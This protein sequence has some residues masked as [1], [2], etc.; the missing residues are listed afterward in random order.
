MKKIIAIVIAASLAAFLVGCGSVLDVIDELADKETQA[1]ESPTTAPVESAAPTPQA[2]PETTLPEPDIPEETQTPERNYDF[3]NTC[4]GMTL[5]EVE[6]AE[7]G[8]VIDRADDWLFFFSEDVAG[9]SA[10]IA[11]GFENGKLANGM[12]MFELDHDNADA[13]IKDFDELKEKLTGLY[14]EPPTDALL[15][16]DDQY[17]EDVQN[18]GTAVAEGQLTYI[19]VWETEITRITLHLRGDNNDISLT[20][21]YD[22]LEDGGAS[23]DS[24]L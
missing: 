19:A 2:P 24:G 12:Y 8:E 16:N 17:K 11:Y 23:E 22:Q 1:T 6:Q 18:Y 9:M 13:Y 14:G 20:L 5:S 15:W 3:R 21:I 4:W 7:G 10:V